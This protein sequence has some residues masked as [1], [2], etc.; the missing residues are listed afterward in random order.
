MISQMNGMLINDQEAIVNVG[1]TKY[2][3]RNVRRARR[4]KSECSASNLHDRNV[5]TIPPHL[6]TTLGG[7]DFICIWST[8][9]PWFMGIY[10]GKARTFTWIFYIW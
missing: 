3:E 5:Y 2:I 6:R 10:P 8:P 7:A 1:S 9:F 4:L